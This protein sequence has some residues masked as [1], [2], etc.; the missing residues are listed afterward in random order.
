MSKGDI[1]RVCKAA[2]LGDLQEHSVICKQRQ[3]PKKRRNWIPER[4][5]EMVD[6]AGPR[7]L[8]KHALGNLDNV[9]L[10]RSFGESYRAA[11][12]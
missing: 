12:P 5:E 10:G 6:K 8:R 2:V 7:F 1:C 4:I 9:R 3:P 11:L